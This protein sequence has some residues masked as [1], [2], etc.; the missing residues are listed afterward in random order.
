MASGTESTSKLPVAA[1]V[2]GVASSCLPP[3]YLVAIVLVVLSLAR[4]R[5]DEARQRR[6]SAIAALG[7]PLLVWPVLLVLIAIPNV[8]RPRHT[9][10]RVAECTSHL[11]AAFAAE[12]AF[13]AEHQRYSMHPVEVGFVPERGNRYLYRFAASGP[14]EER[15]S[16]LSL[17]ALS[18]VGVGPDVHR[19]PDI[20]PADLERALSPALAAELGVHGTC[21][22][23][24]ITMACAGDIDGDATVDVWSISSRARTSDAG[25]AIAPGSPY[26]EVNDTDT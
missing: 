17:P 21:P 12:K 2:V 3:L 14:V 19:F 26:R 18:D 20:V 24:D 25:V 4:S 10:S 23:C 9:R 5:E 15:R 6:A 16:A 8:V 1:L 11:K 13:Y 22:G 7:V